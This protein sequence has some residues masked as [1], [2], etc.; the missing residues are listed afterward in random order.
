MFTILNCLLI[1]LTFETHR[2]RCIICGFILVSEISAL[3][4]A[5]FIFS[6]MSK[7]AWE[8]LIFSVISF[9]VL[10]PFFG[11]VI[12]SIINEQVQETM[13]TINQKNTFQKM[14]DSMQQG[15]CTIENDKIMFMNDLCNLFASNISGLRDFE[16]NINEND[17]VDNV[18]PL[19]R[20]IFYLFKHEED[21][22]KKEGFQKYS[23]SSSGKSQT[24]SIKTKII[25]YSLNDIVQLNA[26]ELSGKIFT[27]D[28]RL[29]QGDLTKINQ[30]ENDQLTGKLA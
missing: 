13:E 9:V 20:K 6:K 1:T 2:Q 26:L 4:F 24:T 5:N 12:L 16:Q 22:E 15:I 17:E 18:N 8:T 27:Y 30:Y 28:K 3:L 21:D 29:A 23:K 19:D 7:V 11:Y 10:V 14:F 25:E